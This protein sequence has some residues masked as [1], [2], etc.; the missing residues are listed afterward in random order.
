MAHSIRMGLEKSYCSDVCHRGCAFTVLQ[1]VQRPRVC[2]DVYDTVHYI[3]PLK[4]FDK[5][6]A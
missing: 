1:T 6:R 2:S 5:G 4:L 3:E